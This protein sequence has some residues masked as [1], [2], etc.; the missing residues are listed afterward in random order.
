MGGGGVTA[1]CSIIFAIQSWQKLLENWLSVEPILTIV[2]EAGYSAMLTLYS[3]FRQIL[4]T[5]KRT[6]GSRQPT[7]HSLNTYMGW[8]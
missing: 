5:I 1:D 2:G 7:D 3:K 6:R 4:L 8:S